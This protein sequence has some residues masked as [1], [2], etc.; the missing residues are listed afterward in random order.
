[1]Y[2]TLDEF[3]FHWDYEAQSTQKLMDL[4]TDSALPQ[5]AY[6]GGRTLGR[7]A[8]HIGQTIP[9]MMGLTGLVVTGIDPHAPAPASAAEIASG[10]RAAAASLVEAIRAQ[11][12]DASLAT[13]DD[14]YGDRWTK[15]MTLSALVSHQ[16]HHRGQMTVLMRQAGLKVTGI[17]GPAEEEW[18]LM[19]ME[20]PPV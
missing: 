11:W 16:I 4:L 6:P 7:L 5:P 15:A 12:T 13:E 19:G 17:Y 10:Y 2:H 1:M 3:A 18:S 20:A 8:W 9:E 14:M